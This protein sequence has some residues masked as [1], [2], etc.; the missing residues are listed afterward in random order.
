MIHS[1][2]VLYFCKDLRGQKN[3]YKMTVE[4]ESMETDGHFGAKWMSVH[5]GFF[6][7]THALK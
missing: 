1:Y 4:H 6:D 2:T 3:N 5:F 7:N